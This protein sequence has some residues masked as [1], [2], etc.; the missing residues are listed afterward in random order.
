[1]LKIFYQTKIFTRPKKNSRPNFFLSQILNKDLVD[2][3]SVYKT[4]QWRWL[5]MEDDL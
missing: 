5:Q 1:M 4:F 2:Q 3:S